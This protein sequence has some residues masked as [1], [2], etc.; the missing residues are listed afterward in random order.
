MRLKL[1]ENLGASAAALLTGAG[2]EVS[3]V[4]EQQMTGWSDEDLFQA[5]SAEGR[6]IVTL[7]LDFANPFRFDPAK[8][9][10]IIVLRP[11][12]AHSRAVIA[13]LL[14]RVVAQLAISDPSGR[15]WI[16]EP[17]RVRQYEPGGD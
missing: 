5:C 12:A 1:D 13:R 10:G 6:A 8:S 17:R 7:D 15:L 4:V 14:E 16:V 11:G 2:L 9:A 3:T